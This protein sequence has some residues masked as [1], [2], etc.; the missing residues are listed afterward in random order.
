MF[1]AIENS[2]KGLQAQC[3]HERR[4][5]LSSAPSNTEKM[6]WMKGQ[7]A[8]LWACRLE[9]ESLQRGQ[10]PQ[11]A[12]LGLSWLS[13]PCLARS[14]SQCSPAQ[15]AQQ[16]CM[17][18]KLGIVE[19]PLDNN[20]SNWHMMRA[21]QNRAGQRKAGQDRTRGQRHSQTEQMKARQGRSRLEQGRAAGEKDRRRAGPSKGKA[22]QRQAGT[23]QDG[24]LQGRAEQGPDEAGQGR[25]K[26]KMDR[27]GQGR[28]LCSAADL[29]RGRSEHHVMPKSP[30]FGHILPHNPASNT[31]MI[32]TCHSETGSCI[33]SVQLHG[34]QHTNSSLV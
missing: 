23:G 17:S 32:C 5:G 26:G 15:H 6:Q 11:A 3:M 30:N 2:V 4:H 13:P 20:N 29:D 27:Q 12:V 18:G 28:E 1:L 8:D 31:C 24:H 34:K 7:P 19:P 21:E 9:R 25:R 33:H 10:W 22:E 14:Q 16:G